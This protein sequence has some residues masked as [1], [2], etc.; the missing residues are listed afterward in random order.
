[1]SFEIWNV[2]SLDELES[3]KS[4]KLAKYVLDLVEVQVIGRT[5]MSLS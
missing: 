4:Q 5:R 2:R 3:L 1:L